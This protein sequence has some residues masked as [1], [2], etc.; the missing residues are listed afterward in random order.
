MRRPDLATRALLAGLV[1]ASGAVFAQ[2]NPPPAPAEPAAAP[3][4]T[5]EAEPAPEEYR[6]EDVIVVTA[7]RTEQS[8]HDAPVTMSVLTTKDIADIPADDAGDL[9]RNIPGLNV[10]QISARDVQVGGREATNSLATGQLVLLD[11][12]S[13]YLD[14]FGFV[15][16][17]FVP[18]DFS[19]LKQVEVVRGPGSAVWGANAFSGVINLISKPPKEI[20][21]TG[22][23][24]GGGE[25]GTLFGSLTHAGVSDKVG[26]KL[27]SGY[28]AQDAYE[29]PV[30][31]PDGTPFPPQ[32][33]GFSQDENQG[34]KQPKADVRVDY[35]ASPEST[36]S[37]SA[38]YAGTDGIIHS[39]IGPFDMQNDTSLSYGKVDWTNLALRV[40]FFYNKLDGEAK[41]L[42]T[43]GTDGKPI[44]FIF[45]TD[46]YNLEFGNTNALGTRTIITYG[47]NARKNEFDL[48]IAPRGDSRDEYGAYSQFD[49]MFG[50]K[51][52]WSVGARYD[53]LDPIGSVVSPR[54]ALVYS[55]GQLQTLRFSFGRAFRA[56]S[57][58]NNYLE[59]RIIPALIPPLVAGAHPFPVV[60]AVNG[61]VDLE[62]E[63]TDSYDL[64]YIGTWG[65]STLSVSVYHNKQRD[66]ID[67]YQKT[68]YSPTNPPPGWPY[69]PI[70]LALIPALRNL[71]AEFSYRN[72]GEIVN[73]GV[74]LGYNFRDNGPWSYF[75][76]YSY[77]KTPKVSGFNADELGRP[78][79]TRANAGLA[80]DGGAFFVN[81]NA[82]YQSEAYFAD[83]LSIQGTTEAFTMLNA[84]V[85]YRFWDERASVSI[86]GQNL[87]DERV[88]QHIFGDIISRKI[89]GQL[90][91]H[92]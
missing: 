40:G 35:D 75:A 33:Q 86:N 24:L 59:T 70:L 29:R 92:F 42:L 41:N 65:P 76:N 73:E 66:I 5:P 88:Q 2:S 67:F 78:P 61:N 56:P 6:A 3:A 32:G 84:A 22:L 44:N 1:L 34:T 85:G 83:V 37:F 90:K 72:L 55:L 12:R 62:E 52:R 57:V 17:D 69:P 80:W 91:L 64:G 71:P 49:F 51:L 21:G 74:E 54:T 8:L 50:D 7:S 11:N 31:F 58:V 38:G 36:L 77:Q 82:N 9:L 16:W 89:S 15:A 39:G 13:L 27:S 81:V 18:L 53:N 48:S 10:S 26:Y 79:K 43:V 20:V 68:S 19:E 4:A 63:K 45:K 28:Y 60:T 46:T 30:G 23:T 47:A 87:T 14:F 25:L